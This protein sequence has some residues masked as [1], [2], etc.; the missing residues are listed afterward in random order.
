MM[1][2]APGA[3]AVDYRDDRLRAGAHRLDEIAGHAGEIEKLRGIELQQGRD[4]LVNIAAGG[5]IAAGAGD[6]ED[7]HVLVGARGLEN[8][9]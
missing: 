4:D 5:E 8:P 7:L 1:A 6:D 2:P 3:H 9:Q